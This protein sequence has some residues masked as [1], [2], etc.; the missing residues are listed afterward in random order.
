MVSPWS[1]LLTREENT[2]VKVVICAYKGTWIPITFSC[3]GDAIGIYH[4]ALLYGEEIFVFPPDLVPWSS[5][6]LNCQ[7]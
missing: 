2:A 5:K 3:L 6:A 1:N 7:N 4:R